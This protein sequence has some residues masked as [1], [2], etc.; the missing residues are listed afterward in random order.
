M[1]FNIEDHRDYCIASDTD[2]C[3]FSAEKF[4]KDKSEEEAI[5]IVRALAHK[6][7]SLLN[8]QMGSF[9]LNLFNVKRHY[10]DF[11]TESIIKSAYWAGK[12]RYAQFIVDKEGVKV[13]ELDMKGLDLMKSNFPPLFRDFGKSLIEDLMFGKTKLEIDK[14]IL[15]FRDSLKNIEWKKLLKPTGIKNLEDYIAKKPN[16]GEIFSHLESGCPINTRSAIQYNDIVRYKKLDKKYPLFQVGDKMYISYLKDNPY[17][18]NCIGFNNFNNPP[19]IIE[20]IETY[21][22][23]DKIF[24]SVMK[25]KIEKVYKDLGWGF[26]TF[27][28]N[29]KKFFK[30]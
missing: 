29:I 21:V 11:K 20:L 24:E 7:S 26:P 25:K 12:R 27:N 13:S 23:R 9:S 14:K 19:E 2:S 16:K 10:F 28:R 15:D 17:R 30:F 8:N 6:H 5:E 1:R 4:V 3:F 22:D 18:I